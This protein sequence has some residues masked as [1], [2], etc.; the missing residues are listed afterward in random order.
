M[1]YYNNTL[2]IKFVDFYLMYIFH[3]FV[4]YNLINLVMKKNIFI[5]VFLAS[6]ICCGCGNDEI[7]LS[8]AF[9]SNSIWNGTLTIPNEPQ[10]DILYIRITFHDNNIGDYRTFED[11]SMN[12]IIDGGTF[13]YSLRG[14]II[15]FYG[16]GARDITG[17]WWTK[18]IS[19]E[20]FEII[21]EPKTKYESTL[22][23]K[24]IKL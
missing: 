4:G 22:N 20:N 12:K 7:F 11:I 23:L 6:Y 3:T 10:K 21:R 5:P 18:N 24:A 2:I 14:D 16:E 8:D 15:S 17:D 1:L 9:L 13:Q 19:K